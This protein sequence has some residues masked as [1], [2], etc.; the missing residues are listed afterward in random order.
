MTTSSSMDVNTSSYKST[1]SQTTTTPR[2]G[3]SYTYLSSS[4]SDSSRADNFTDRIL[5]GTSYD[6][7][8]AD[9]ERRVAALS[10][11]IG[12]SSTSTNSSTSNTNGSG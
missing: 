9:L 3:S 1:T 4:L 6:T 12:G 7:H 2:S 11:T 8:R 5:T 10:A